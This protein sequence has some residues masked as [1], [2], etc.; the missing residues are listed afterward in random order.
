MN[1]QTLLGIYEK[2][3]ALIARLPGPLQKAILQEL[4]PIKQIFL[5]QRPARLALL[6]S[7]R[8]V[9]LLVSGGPEAHMTWCLRS[10]RLWVRKL[11]F[12]SLDQVFC[13]ALSLCDPDRY[14]SKIG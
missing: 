7:V 1:Q 9:Y 5:A 13:H 12:P 11:R 8:R 6:T 10:S 14:R 3:E 4:R 2:I